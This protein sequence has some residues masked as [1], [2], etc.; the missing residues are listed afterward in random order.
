MA[1]GQTR[2]MTRQRTALVATGGLL[3]V[4]G[5]LAAA[6]TPWAA[7]RS[8]GRWVYDLPDALTT[9]LEIV[10]QAGTKLAIVLVAAGLVVVGRHRAALAA[11]LAGLAAWLLASMLKAWVDRPRPTFASLGRVPRETVD[12]GAWPSSHAAIAFALATV[13]LLTVAND[14]LGRAL[15]LT[16]AVLTAVARIHLG[17]HWTLDVIGGA[18][19][20]AL[21]G[22]VAVQATKA[23]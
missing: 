6:R 16:V 3:V 18:A 19:L 5:L 14:R 7:E 10:M 4:A 17:V 22:L 13:L 1:T 11:G 12:N 23:T 8:I 20:G 9:P 21:C 2:G 15:V